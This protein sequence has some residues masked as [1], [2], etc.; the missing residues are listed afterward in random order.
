MRPGVIYNGIAGT[1]SPES[2]RMK[3]THTI[4]RYAVLL[5][6]LVVPILSAC[7]KTA[8]EEKKV[9]TVNGA[10]ILLKD[11]EKE[12]AR[13]ARLDPS[14]KLTPETLEKALETL[15]E[16]KLMIQ[17]AVKEGLSADERFLDA[18]KEHW[19]QTLIRILIDSKAGEWSDKLFVTEDE[20]RL[21]H[22]RMGARLTVETL[23]AR[24]KDE[25]L[26][27]KETAEKGKGIPGARVSGPLLVEDS[28]MDDPLYR[29]FDMKE[30]V[31]EVI[32]ARGGYLVVRVVKREAVE[33]PPLVDAR[34]EIKSRIT[35]EKKRKALTDWLLDIRSSARVETDALALRKAGD[36]R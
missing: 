8:P 22:A 9:A 33:T 3:K 15:I 36:G 24:S 16:R 29:A 19:E 23:E 30:G 17:E 35:E 25:A 21:Y 11:F 2:A 27:A 6:I 34:A 1:E 7:G 18:V 20:I 31:T 32:Q 4:S 12:V 13:A 26:A 10:P 5:V 14:L 28:G